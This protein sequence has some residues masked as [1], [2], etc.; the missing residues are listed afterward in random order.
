M[1]RERRLNTD[2]ALGNKQIC[3]LVGS[4]TDGGVAIVYRGL[5]TDSF[6]PDN[7]DLDFCDRTIVKKQKPR[8][9]SYVR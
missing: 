7:I 9:E 5:K 8:G 1:A 2:Y 6:N 3:A 4:F